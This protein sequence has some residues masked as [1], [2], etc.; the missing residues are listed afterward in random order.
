MKISSINNT[1]SF[2]RA[3]KVNSVSN[4][5]FP[6]EGRKVDSSTFE[7]C[8]VLNN[9][10]SDIYSKDE[11][12][13]IKNFFIN[14]LG[15]YNGN[16]SILMRRTQQGDVVMLSGQEAKDIKQLEKEKAKERSKIEKDHRKPSRIKQILIRNTFLSVSD[17]INRK[18]EDGI[19]GK[20]ESKLEFNA[21]SLSQNEITNAQLI[22]MQPIEAKIDNIK[23]YSYNKHYNAEN[24][25]CLN[26]DQPISY[27]QTNRTPFVNV[28]FHREELKL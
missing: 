18:V 10:Q 6:K 13:Q 17:E 5:E 9:Q 26:P 27:K 4:P 21:S 12:K 7:I 3:I 25:G 1:N 8:R 2:G 15:D 11:A 16:N 22:G 24:D 19:A 23:Y 14:I 28:N 20:P